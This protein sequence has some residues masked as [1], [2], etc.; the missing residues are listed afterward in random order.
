MGKAIR[1]ALEW[2]NSQASKI[3]S[4]SSKDCP[5]KKAPPQSQGM[6]NA[7]SCYS[8]AAWNSN[9]C[10]GGL[11]WICYKPDGTKL[12]QGSSAHQIIASVLVAEALSLNAAIKAAIAHGAKDLVCFSDSK[13]LISLITGNMSVISLQGILHDIGVLSR[14][15][16]SISF[17][18]VSRNGNVDADS[19]AKSALFSV[20]NSPSGI[21]NDVPS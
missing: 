2:Q 7:F 14:S 12:L 10:A 19:L 15:L 17:K 21:V 5:T 4:A 11:G 6:E 3:P 18:F 13:S 16:S 1:S 8:D 9:S 20:S